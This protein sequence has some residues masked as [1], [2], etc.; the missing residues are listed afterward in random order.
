MSKEK[1]K[2]DI[3][4]AFEITKELKFHNFTS[5]ETANIDYRK[6]IVQVAGLIGQER[7]NQSINFE[8]EQEIPRLINEKEVP[9][10]KDQGTNYVSVKGYK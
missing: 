3:I 6:V 1:I 5:I 9:I 4:D 2:Q 7:R 8:P 10:I